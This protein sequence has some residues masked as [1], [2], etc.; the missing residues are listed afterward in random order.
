MKSFEA[1]DE[2]WT[3]NE[4]ISK[5][6]TDDYGYTKTPRIIS[7]AT[8]MIKTDKGVEYNEKTF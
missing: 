4:A 3:M 5:V 1:C 6:Y 8:D 7:N 2:C